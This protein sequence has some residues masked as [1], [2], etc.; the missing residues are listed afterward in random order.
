MLLQFSEG[1]PGAGL[2]CQSHVCW[3]E[4]SN[5][6]LREGIGLLEPRLLQL[7]DR[8]WAERLTENQMLSPCASRDIQNKHHNKRH[9]GP[10]EF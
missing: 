7:N 8:E 1:E 10:E 2:T 3:C 5:F 9:L 6:I 4:L